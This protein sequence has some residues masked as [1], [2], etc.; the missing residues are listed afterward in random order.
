MKEFLAQDLAA[1]HQN[2]MQ[3]VTDSF[4]VRDLDE[5]AKS[6]KKIRGRAGTA[7]KKRKIAEKISFIKKVTQSLGLRSTTQQAIR[8]ERNLPKANSDEIYEDLK[9]LSYRYYDE[10]VD[11]TFLY[12]TSDKRQFYNRTTPLGE[13]GQAHFPAANLEII[14][15]SN[16]Y[17]F[18][19]YTAC[20]FHLVRACEVGVKALYKTL[21]IA[22][23]KLG[24]SWGNLLKPMD[25]ELKKPVKDR[26]DL[27]SKESEFFDSAT[28]DV[29][30]IKRAWR[31]ST[32]HVQSAYDESSALKVFLAVES[33]FRHLSR[34][35]NEEGNLI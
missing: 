21:G 7:A 27:W 16:C 14:E 35:I 31:D 15:A 3:I 22:A 1:I 26:C 9:S 30:A 8:F 33:F 23:P 29:R 11:L 19:R 5:L 13:L 10:I 12:L 17:A 20:V 4:R 18:E 34:K 2:I 32:M 25:D 24:N 28:N 6:G